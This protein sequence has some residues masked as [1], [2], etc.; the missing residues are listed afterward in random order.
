MPHE[1]E[2]HGDDCKKRNRNIRG[3]IGLAHRSAQ[4]CDHYR[5]AYKAEKHSASV[6]SEA[7]HIF[8]EIVSTSAKN[9]PLIR[10]KRRGYSDKVRNCP[11]EHVAI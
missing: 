10:K 6:D 2:P 7:S 11:G 5:K 3:I 4:D 8:D 1:T 9:K